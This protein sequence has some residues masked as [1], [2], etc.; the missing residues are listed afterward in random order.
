MPGKKAEVKAKES[1][2][3]TFP[4]G[5]KK[6]FPKDTQVLEVVQGIGPKLAKEAVSAS[7]NGKEVDLTQAIQENA[8][9]TVHTFE[10]AQGKDT[11]WHSTSHLMAMAV[12]EL[13]PGA[14]ITIGPAINEGFYYDIDYDRPF[15]PEDLQRIEARMKELAKKD[16][17]VTRHEWTKKEA[18]EY[19]A[20]K[21]QAY[22][23][24]LIDELQDKTVSVYEEGN[25]TDLCT[26]PHVV[27]TGKINAIKLLRVSGAYWKGD[28]KNKQLQRVYG[29]SFPEQKM[30]DE[31]VKQQEQASARNHVKLGKEMDLYSFHEESPG[32]AFFHAKGMTLYNALLE[33]MREKYRVKEYKEISTPIILKKELWIRSGHWDHYKENM[34]F[35]KIDDVEQAIKP[36]NCPGSIL[37]YKNAR[38]SYKELPLKLAEFGI[39]HRHELSGVLN[40][41]FRLRKFM[42]DDA[43]IYCT[44][45]QL[46]Q[47]IPETIEMVDEVYKAFGFE[48]KVELSTR[49]KDSMG[50]E[51]LWTTATKAL[52]DA[53]NARKVKFELREGEGAFYGPKIDFHVKDSLGR[54]W[55]CGTI[56]VDFQ[57]PER[58]DL[59][60][61]G[62]DD[63]EHRPVMVHRAI[64]GSLERFLGILV[65]H[66]AG[67]FPLWL[68]PVQVKVLPLSE[69][70]EDYA[71]SVH[72]ELLQ[73]GIRSEL[74]DSGETLQYRIRT[75][76]LEK[77]PY[78]IV[79]GEKE[80]KGK[81]I[82][83]RDREGKQMFGVQLAAF[84]ADAKKKA[85]ERT[86]A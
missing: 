13:F 21:R 57:M 68:S 26:G 50:A 48:Y 78:I 25:F 36:M 63:K 24:K 75:A 76:S 61:I 28:A 77:I 29:I 47:V 40:G 8:A 33:F 58:F 42:Q 38:R 34:Y 65:E 1:I 30:L 70:F 59:T 35:T 80:E 11:Y 23:V 55:Q 83:V 19:F 22:K 84:I 31:W 7:L 71:K 67:R 14:Q 53:L 49:P 74:N 32:N 82:A 44:P 39:D 10:H 4:D 17:K 37:V 6:Q 46:K 12:L 56:Q 45:E 79:V 5:S 86:E 69:K 81:T 20:K 18:K 15:T 72:H 52:H 66:Y 27:S 43:H 85:I 73:S 54:T 51:E 3:V 16:L 9:L 62:S 2:A 60:Y 64:Y 41:L